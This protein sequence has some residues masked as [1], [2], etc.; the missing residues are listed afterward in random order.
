MTAQFS[1]ETRRLARSQRNSREIP[2]S[3]G[4]TPRRPETMSR[5][6]RTTRRRQ[7]NFLG[8]RDDALSPGTTPRLPRKFSRFPGRRHVSAEIALSLRKTAQ[9]RGRRAV[10]W[11]HRRVSR[12]GAAISLE[13]GASPWTLA[14]L[15]ENHAVSAEI[16]PSSAETRRFFGKP[17]RLPRRHAV[18]RGDASISAETRRCRGS[19]ANFSGDRAILWRIS[20]VPGSS[21]D[22]PGDLHPVGKAACPR[23]GI[24]VSHRNGSPARS[25]STHP[26]RENRSRRPEPRR[27]RYP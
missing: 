9:R 24:P 7:G 23:S 22:L 12:D 3:P 17:P 15:R 13:I 18:S 6:P 2:P 21:G 19:Y 1:W 26:A 10:V 5:R 20:R 4:T 25:P 8:S 11:R 14:H 27:R 16:G